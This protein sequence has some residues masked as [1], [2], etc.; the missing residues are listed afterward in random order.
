MVVFGFV[1]A[2]GNPMHVHVQ[3]TGSAVIEGQAGDAGF[4]GGL[5]QRNGLAG[6]FARLGVTA[7][8]HP[9]VELPVVQQ[10]HPT[11][12]G[13]N[14]ESTADEVAVG[15]P[16]VEWILVGRGERD[17]ALEIAGLV[18]VGRR[19]RAKSVFNYHGER[20]SIVAHSAPREL[21]EGRW[22]NDTKK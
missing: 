19:V 14:D 2:S 16:A 4:L 7:T 17:D 5:T 1:R 10:Q 6:C 15:V 21:A 20:I 11:P 13:G 12:V 9:A 3:G 8:L 22:A 18:V